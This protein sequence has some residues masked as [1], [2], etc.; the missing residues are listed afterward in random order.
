MQQQQPDRSRLITIMILWMVMWF[1][2]QYFFFKPQP[3]PAQAQNTLAQAQSL[4][5]EGRKGDPRQISLSDRVKKLDAAIRAYEEYYQANKKSPEGMQA[6]FQEVNILDYLVVNAKDAGRYDQAEHLLKEME[7]GFRGHTGTVTLEENGET[8]KVT[9]DLGQIAGA[10]L[11]AI[12]YAR[13][14]SNRNKITWQILNRLVL[15]T[16]RLPGFS[17]FFALA[18]VVIVLKTITFPFQK[19]QYQYA[20]DMARIQP[21]VKEMQE[22]MKGRPQ[23][24]INRRMMELYKE[25]NVSLTGGCLPMLVLLFVLWPV[26]WMVRD[27]EYQFTFAKF[28]WI[29]SPISYKTWWLGQNLAQFDV[30]LFVIYL[31]TMVASSLMQPKPADPQQAQQQ[32]IMMLSTPLIFSVFMWMYQW[33]SAFML[34]W[35][36]LNVVSMYQSWILMKRYGTGGSGPA[37][38][39]AVVASQPAPPPVLEPMKGVRTKN[40]NSGNGRNGRGSPGGMPDRVRPRRPGRRN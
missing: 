11:N 24:E 27:Y 6:R 37:G 4:E 17:Y 36:V 28:L 23:E 13:D 33:S 7:K 20:Q 12:R 5:A 19:K 40:P 35:L 22:R 34:Y 29:G 16:G 1:G 9:G 8:R 18:L 15:L 25:N 2:L 21:L 3:N 26:Y 14:Q 10:R 32:R 39:A 31:L 30:P 38:G